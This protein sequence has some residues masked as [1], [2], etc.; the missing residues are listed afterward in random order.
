MRPNVR[1][2]SHLP[3]LGIVISVC[4]F[5]VATTY[6]PG[7]TADSATSVGYDWAHNF[8]S[9]LFAAKALNGAANPARLFAIPAMLVLCV[10]IGALF[11]S[12]SNKSTSKIH[13]KTIEISGIGA[14]VYAFLV[15][16]PMHNVMVSAGSTARRPPA[17]RIATLGAPVL[18]CRTFEAVPVGEPVRYRIPLVPNA[19]RFRAGHTMRLYLTTDDQDADTPALLG[20]DMPASAR[21]HSTRCRLPRGYCCQCCEVMSPFQ[22]RLTLN[23]GR[24]SPRSCSPGRGRCGC[25]IRRWRRGSRRHPYRNPG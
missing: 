10:S 13:R 23:S 16:T 12:I 3:L 9:S 14:T 8:I 7:G 17:A 22:N 25:G 2:R 21:A 11:K 4:L 20:S 18:P 15:V 19:R 6:Y 1:F 24:S 5:F